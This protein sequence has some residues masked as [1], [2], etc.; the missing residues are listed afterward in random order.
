MV[1]TN[2]SIFVVQD[3]I[4][5]VK[6]TLFLVFAFFKFNTNSAQKLGLGG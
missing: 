5:S 2:W 1:Q 6:K 3:D 4:Y